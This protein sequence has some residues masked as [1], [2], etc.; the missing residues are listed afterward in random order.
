MAEKISL[1]PP[2]GV[3]A[4]AKRGIELVGQGKAGDGFEPATL[5][6]ARKIAAGQELTPDHVKRMYSFF[7]RHSVDRKAD[8]GK[9]GQETPGYVAW[10]AWGGDA[11]ASWSARMVAKMKSLNMED[12]MDSN[13][14]LSEAQKRRQEILDGRIE[15]AVDILLAETGKPGINYL[16]VTPDA[17]YKLRGLMQYY[18]KKPHPFRACVRDNRKRFGPRTEG[19]C[20]VLK[21][22][23]MNTTKWRHGGGKNMS[24]DYM[25]SAV[26]ATED[27]LALSTDEP[28]IIDDQLAAVLLQIDDSKMAEVESLLWDGVE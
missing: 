26:A 18:A 28:P 10:M 17:R 12:L 23:I 13:V 27:G 1:V 8:W 20:A 11:G 6:R 21:D 15:Q 4:A 9:S 19:V 16:Q 25:F 2:S 3:R 22:L 7:R 14:A 24:E 5:A